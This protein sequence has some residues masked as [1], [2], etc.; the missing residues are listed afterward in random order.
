MPL[1]LKNFNKQHIPHNAW[2]YYNSTLWL[3]SLSQDWV[4]WYTIADKNLWATTVWNS[5]D[6][7]SQANCWKM[8]QFWNNY[9]FPYTWATTTSTTQVNAQNYWPGNYYS[10]STFIKNS[11]DW[12]SSFNYNRRWWITWTNEAKRWPCSE[13]FHVPSRNEWKDIENIWV[14]LNVNLNVLLKMPYAWQLLNDSWNHYWAENNWNYWKYRS[15]DWVSTST[16]SNRIRHLSNNNSTYFSAAQWISASAWASIRPFKNDP[17]IPD[18]TWTTLHDWGS[19]V[20]TKW[21]YYNEYQQIISL[22]DD[23]INWLTISDRNQNASSRYDYWD[24]FTQANCWLFY[25]R[26]NNYSFAFSWSITTSSTQVDARGYWPWNYYSSSTF[27]YRSNTPRDWSSYANDNL[28]WWTTGTNEARKW[29]CY[30][31]H[32][33]S[34]DELTLLKNIWENIWAWNA[35]N[36]WSINV[37]TYL[38]I[39]MDWYR[40]ASSWSITSQWI[41]WYIWSSDV[42]TSWDTAYWWLIWNWP[43]QDVI[44]HR[45]ADAVHI[46][47]FYNSSVIPNSNW[48]VVYQPS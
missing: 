13:W 35:S 33:P 18:D 38:H 34:K 44:W 30:N 47:P 45:I 20:R 2:V 16:A 43:Y 31:A 39:P 7:L 8:Y 23:W 3:I 46:R 29:P 37:S 24:A 25:Q 42:A 9:W 27:I 17:I 22:S 48:T 11:T 15:T 1:T 19:T 41:Y 28:W 6:T 32:I 40:I 14:N 5:W 26:W 36:Q 12:D 21:I 4:N 10:S